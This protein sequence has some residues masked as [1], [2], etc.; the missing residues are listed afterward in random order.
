MNAKSPEK[1]D[2]QNV[3]RAALVI[4]T[5]V[6]AKEQGMRLTDVIERTGLGTATVHRLLTGLVTHGFLDHDRAS[7]RYFLGLR[8][9]S[10]A[11]AATERYGLYPFVGSSLDALSQA[12]ADTVYFSL[13]SGMDAICVDRREGSFPIKT[14]TLSVGDRRPLGVGAGSLAL[15]AFQDDAFVEAVLSAEGGQ[16]RPPGF[17]ADFLRSAVEQTR[18]AGFALNDGRLIAGMS[19]VAVPIRQKDGRAIAAISIAAIS[20]RLDGDRLT[21]IIAMLKRETESIEHSAA[22]MLSGPFARRHTTRG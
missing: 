3:S 16:T 17:D 18:K 8:M 11:A 7:N 14:L 9:L 6:R 20:S 19:A 10:W 15:L 21:E 12:S 22:D 2:H 5:L 1:G 4:D 13:V